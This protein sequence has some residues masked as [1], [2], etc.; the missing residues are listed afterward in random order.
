MEHQPIIFQSLVSHF[1]TQ[2]KTAELLKVD[3]ATVSGWVRGKHGM[4]PA[5]ALRAEKLTKGKFTAVQLCP[6]VFNEPSVQEV[7]SQ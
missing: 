3:Q 1:G 7:A 6:S 2:V 4:S 5:V